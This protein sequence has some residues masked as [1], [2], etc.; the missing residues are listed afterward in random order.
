MDLDLPQAKAL[1][2]IT[3]T[4]TDNPS[5]EPSR[6]FYV[7]NLEPRKHSASHFGDL[8]R[9][10]WGGCESRNHWVRDA[11]MREDDTRVKN[12]NINCVLACL[13]VA[14]ISLKHSFYHDLSWPTLQELSQHN[15]SFPYQ[16]IINHR[17]KP[18]PK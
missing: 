6:S 7:T 5:E 1:I 15:T 4:S 13:R 3:R 8:A 10:H 11:L 17:A 16:A 9:G 2:L 14:V 12:F 18:L